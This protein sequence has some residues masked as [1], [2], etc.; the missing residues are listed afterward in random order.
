MTIPLIILAAAVLAFGIQ[1][2]FNGLIESIAEALF[3]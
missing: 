3:V 1:P 2:V